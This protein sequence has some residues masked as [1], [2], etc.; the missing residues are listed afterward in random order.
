MR[1]S[2]VRE[3]RAFISTRSGGIQSIP[4]RAAYQMVIIF[5]REWRKF[6]SPFY[7]EVETL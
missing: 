7:F 3:K 4:N 1:K 5:T 6:N 2:V